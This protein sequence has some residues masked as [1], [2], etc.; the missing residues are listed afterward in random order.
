MLTCSNCCLW[1]DKH[2]FTVIFLERHLHYFSLKK[3][4]KTADS[5]SK[6]RII[7]SQVIYLGG[8]CCY[9]GETSWLSYVSYTKKHKIFQ[10]PLF[11]L[12]HFLWYLWRWN[13]LDSKKYTWTWLACKIIIPFFRVLH[14]HTFMTT[15]QGTSHYRALSCGKTYVQFCLR[16]I[17][18]PN[19]SFFLIQSFRS[20]SWCTMGLFFSKIVCALVFI[21]WISG[22]D[23]FCQCSR[24]INGSAIELRQKLGALQIG[25]DKKPSENQWTMNIFF[26]QLVSSLLWGVASDCVQRVID[27]SLGLSFS[28]FWV[29]LN[30]FLNVNMKQKMH[31]LNSLENFLIK[32][33]ARH[34]WMLFYII[35][36]IVV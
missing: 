11:K 21:I 12:G 36:Q 32:I 5:I 14:S 25:Y 24:L 8:K 30:Q 26:E 35:R 18:P 27:L 23:F 2:F 20:W 13:E 6:L 17:P 31:H 33:Y 9:F 10:T 22:S 34:P 3:K 28:T 19:K 29:E 16:K 4:T 7:R 15:Q 1:G